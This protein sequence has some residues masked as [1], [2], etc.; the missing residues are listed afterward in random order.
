M[1]QIQSRA[2]IRSEEFLPN[3]P[4]KSYDVREVIAPFAEDGAY[5]LRTNC[6]P[7]K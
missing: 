4:K 6:W 3:D 7:G 5:A 1:S 2:N